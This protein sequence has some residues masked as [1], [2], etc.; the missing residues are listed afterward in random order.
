MDGTTDGIDTTLSADEE[1][2]KKKPR[3]SKPSFRDAVKKIHQDA[4]QATQI[5]R[6]YAAADLARAGPHDKD[7]DIVPK[8]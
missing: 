2:P 4:A 5:T 6:T 1:T 8:K 3:T 7:S